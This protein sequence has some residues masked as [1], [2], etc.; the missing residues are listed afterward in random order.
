MLYQATTAQRLWRHLRCPRRS[1]GIHGSN[2]AAAEAWRGS[3]P[4]QIIRRFFCAS[5]RIIRFS[6]FHSVTAMKRG[7]RNW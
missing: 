6:E 5:L 2:A 3:R 1:D 7:A 4:Y